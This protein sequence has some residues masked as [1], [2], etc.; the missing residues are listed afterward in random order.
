MNT[1]PNY[2]TF[3]TL[4]KLSFLA[5]EAVG[6]GQS[7][8]IKVSNGAI[9]V[10]AIPYPV[11]LKNCKVFKEEVYH[12]CNMWALYKISADVIEEHER[13]SPCFGVP[14]KTRS[15]WLVI[16]FRQVNQEFKRMEY[17]LSTTN[18]M[19]QNTSGFTFFMSDWPEHGILINRTHKINTKTTQS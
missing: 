4:T 18:K 13:A 10:W 6:K 9:P 16:D 8:M 19:F 12:Q 7:V 17:P 15:T 2:Y 1:S 11:P 3:Y 5:S 14:K